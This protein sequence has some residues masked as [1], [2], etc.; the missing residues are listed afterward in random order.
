MFSRAREGK[1]KIESL[2]ESLPWKRFCLRW[3]SLIFRL[4]NVLTSGTHFNWQFEILT[5][6]FCFSWCHRQLNTSKQLIRILL[7][8]SRVLIMAHLTFRHLHVILIWIYLVNREYLKDR[9]FI[10][11][12]GL[13]CQLWSISWGQNYLF[14][15]LCLKMQY[16]VLSNNIAISE[17]IQ[18]YFNFHFRES[19]HYKHFMFAWLLSHRTV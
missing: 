8:C 19:A 13:N 15:F 5:F 16:Q 14:R 3:S 2:D 7:T 6:S 12:N 4:L 9:G 1:G 18:K 17:N 11:Q 10:L